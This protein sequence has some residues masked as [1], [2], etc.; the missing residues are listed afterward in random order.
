MGMRWQR[1]VWETTQSGKDKRTTY[2]GLG[3]GFHPSSNGFPISMI[4][5]QLD[6]PTQR[7]SQIITGE[8]VE[9]FGLGTGPLWLLSLMTYLQWALRLIRPF[10]SS[11][12]IGLF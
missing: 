5:N 12:N 1:T 11:I 10:G 9:E 3:L 6:D 7:F 2:M 4:G 8:T